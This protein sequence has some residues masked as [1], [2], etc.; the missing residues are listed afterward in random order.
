M[1]LT[2]STFPQDLRQEQLEHLQSAQ[3]LADH[4]AGTSFDSNRQQQQQLVQQSFYP[5]MKKQ[6]L[7]AF[8]S[9]LRP[10]Q[11]KP[12]YSRLSLQQLT[13][14]ELPSSALLLLLL[15][16]IILVDFDKSFE[17]SLQQ[18]CLSKAQGGELTI[19]FPPASCT[20]CSLTACTLMSLSFT[21]AVLKLCSLASRRRT[22]RSRT[23][24][25]QTPASSLQSLQRRRAWR[26]RSSST[27]ASTRTTFTTR[28]W[29]K[30]SCSFA[31]WRTT[32]LRPTTSRRT[33]SSRAC[34]MTT[35]QPS[36]FRRTSFSTSFST[37]S[38]SP[39]TRT[40]SLT[41]TTLLSIFLIIFSF[42]MDIANSSLYNNE[43]SGT[44][45]EE[46][47]ESEANLKA[48]WLQLFQL[49]QQIQDRELGQQEQNRQLTTSLAF[50]FSSFRPI[51]SSFK[52]FCGIRSLRSLW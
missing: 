5:K 23:R 13:P 47:V 40:R 18:L 49:Q 45:P 16:V 38:T 10:E 14:D 9:Q 37:A 15:V 24:A 1:H 48:K 34:R 4:L 33:T 51:S 42:N 17:L 27:T 41:S 11:P 29:R 6:N 32:A 44:C 26:Q 19:A 25:L 28:A 39:L 20:S 7:A 12:A 50:N 22:R 35:C 46:L 21:V 30:K 2:R 52:T 3:L 31:T 36:A 43:L 8:Q